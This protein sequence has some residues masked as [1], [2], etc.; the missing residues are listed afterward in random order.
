MQDL[1]ITNQGQELIAKM[2]AGTSTAS[3][4]KIQTSDY[5]YSKETLKNLTFLYDVKQEALISSVTRTDT[6]MVEVIGAVN[7]SELS[8]GY[9]VKALGLF[10]SDIDGNEIL[11]AVCIEPDNPDYMPAFGGKTVSGIT[12]K[13]NT[14]VD[15]SSQVTLEISPAAVP[16]MEQVNNLTVIVNQLNILL[17]NKADASHTHSASEVSGLPT[18]LP[19]NGGNAET[20]GNAAVMTTAALG[21][22]RMASGTAA[23]TSANCPPGCWYGQYE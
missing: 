5:D 21:L 19:A 4:T 11:Y 23:A 10:A 18:S 12:Y 6:T 13:M 14:K 15:I 1:I 3:F 2:I 22:H 17:N 20:V 7:N 8:A 16:T 9:Y